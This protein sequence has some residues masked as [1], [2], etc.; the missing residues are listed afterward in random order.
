LVSPRE[1]VNSISHKTNFICTYELLSLS[2]S[3]SRYMKPHFISLVNDDNTTQANKDLNDL[4]FSRSAS[5][6][7]LNPACYG[8]FVTY[9]S[10]CVIR[11]YNLR[12][13]WL[14]ALLRKNAQ[15]LLSQPN[16]WV[17]RITQQ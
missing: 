2:L 8:A 16:W 3:V 6:D 13:S 14:G 12:H 17:T 11:H 15:N 4:A 10:S 9:R 7:E 1:N 5:R